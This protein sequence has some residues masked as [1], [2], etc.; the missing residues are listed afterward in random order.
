MFWFELEKKAKS[1]EWNN[2]NMNEKFILFSVNG[3]TKRLVELAENRGNLIL[4]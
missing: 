1:V 2:G 3:Y 4:G